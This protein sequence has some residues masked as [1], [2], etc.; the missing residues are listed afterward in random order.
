MRNINKRTFS[1]NKKFLL[2]VIA[3]LA[4]YSV[5]RASAIPIAF[6][7][8]RF[9]SFVNGVFSDQHVK[10]PVFFSETSI[11]GSAPYAFSNWSFIDSRNSATIG[12]NFRT[13]HIGSAVPENTLAGAVF[14]FTLN[15]RVEYSFSGQLYKE[16]G[17]NG[18]FPQNIDAMGSDLFLVPAPNTADTAI[19]FG[20]GVSS[21]NAGIFTPPPQ[22]GILERGQYRWT[23]RAQSLSGGQSQSSFVLT[24]NRITGQ[25]NQG[26][27]V[28]DAGSTL[29]LL[30]LA[31]CGLG[32]LK[33]NL[34]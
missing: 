3:L 19:I 4:A 12:G 33:R 2:P 15:E 11:S 8:I 25:G 27:H 6:D 21:I 18:L 9:F 5:Q 7:Q 17:W 13:S 23:N 26:N 24:F 1:I 16:F 20:S 29:G 30:A 22:T 28:P 31:I 14:I 34:S 10:D 32:F